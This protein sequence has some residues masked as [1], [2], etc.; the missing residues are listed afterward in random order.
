MWKSY[1]QSKLANLLFARELSRRLSGTGVTVYAVHP[2]VVRTPIWAN[3][4]AWQKCLLRSAEAVLQERCVG[5]QDESVLRDVAEV[6]NGQW[7]ILR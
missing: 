6:G 7:K 3:A 1:S 5:R 4:P 2:G